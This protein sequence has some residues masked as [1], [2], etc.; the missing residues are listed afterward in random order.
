MTLI[1]M[2]HRQCQ[3]LAHNWSYGGQPGHPEARLPAVPDQAHS[4]AVLVQPL[5]STASC[6]YLLWQREQDSRGAGILRLLS[7]HLTGQRGGDTSH[8]TLRVHSGADC[9][10]TGGMAVSWGK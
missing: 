7:G 1:S 4:S 9:K 3:S 8:G 6:G 5:G 10:L 2:V